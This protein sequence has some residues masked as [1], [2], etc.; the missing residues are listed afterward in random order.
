MNSKPSYNLV[1][2]QICCKTQFW[3]SNRGYNFCFNSDF[4]DW[5]YNIDHFH[6]ESPYPPGYTVWGYRALQ[7][8]PRC[9][10]PPHGSGWHCYGGGFPCNTRSR[11]PARPNLLKRRTYQKKLKKVQR[12]FTVL[13]F[14]SFHP[15]S[16]HPIAAWTLHHIET[17]PNGPRGVVLRH[18]VSVCGWVFIILLLL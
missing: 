5:S 18:I 4:E 16:G 2:T 12:F 8:P 1:V 11:P 17:G 15:P 6:F 13:L 3:R 7:A 10:W 14:F 9:R